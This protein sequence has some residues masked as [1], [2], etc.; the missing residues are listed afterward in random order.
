[1]FI[2]VSVMLGLLGMFGGFLGFLMKEMM[3]F[4][5]LI[6]IMLKFEVLLRGMISMLMVM[7]VFELMCWCSISL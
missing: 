2:E 5:L 3:L 7:F 4:L 6:V 1:M